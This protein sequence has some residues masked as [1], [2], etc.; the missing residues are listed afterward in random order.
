MKNIKSFDDF[1]KLNEDNHLPTRNEKIAYI[2]D[3]LFEERE[4][5]QK[6]KDS[7]QT[8]LGLTRYF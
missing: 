7:H 2:I 1:K 3:H 5:L 6:E 4:K 8:Q